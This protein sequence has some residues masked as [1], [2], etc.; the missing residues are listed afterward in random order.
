VWE[1]GQVFIF[2]GDAQPSSR[3]IGKRGQGA[4]RRDTIVSPNQLILMSPNRAWLGS[5]TQ[6]FQSLL[7]GSVK[8]GEEC[9]RN[10]K[11]CGTT[12]TEHG[13]LGGLGVLGGIL[14]R[15]MAV[16]NEKP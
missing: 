15:S 14:L 3:L 11:G 7:L 10:L 12:G 6:S 13:G 4:F 2:S 9:D 5:G 8:S 16:K 1:K